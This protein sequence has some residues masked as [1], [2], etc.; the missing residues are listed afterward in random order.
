[1]GV[2]CRSR[3]SYRPGHASPRRTDPSF[4]E[5]DYRSGCPSFRPR[6]YYDLHRVTS[7]SPLSPLAGIALHLWVSIQLRAARRLTRGER[8]VSDGLMAVILSDSE[9]SLVRPTLRLTG[10]ASS[11]SRM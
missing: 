2:A 10:D 7:S 11:L 9:G 8:L 4:S 5:P 3:I 6:L 1:M